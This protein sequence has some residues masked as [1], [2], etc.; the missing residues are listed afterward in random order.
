M[1]KLT[2]KFE[3][4][5]LAIRYIAS[6]QNGDV[7]TAREI[8]EETSIPYE[9]VAKILQQLT[10]SKIVSS[11]QGVK[12]GYRLNKPA[13]QISLSEIADAIGDPIQLMEC[14]DGADGCSATL[15]CGIKKPLT[16]IQSRFREIFNEAK[17]AEM[18]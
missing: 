5:L 17:V 2:K 3:Y 8:A 7:A 15:G 1:L 13:A 9:L 18:L 10:R 14:G 16:K 4:G 11:V 12:G 6:T